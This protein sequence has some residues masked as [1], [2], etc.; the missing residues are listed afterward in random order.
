MNKKFDNKIL[1]VDDDPKNL[2]VAMN[3]LK[4]YNVI[5]AQSGEKALTLLEKNK[6]DLIL[7][8]IVMP[9]MDGYTVCKEIKKNINLRNIPIIFLTVK[10]EEKDIVK[11]FDLG[12][13]DYVTKP[14]FSQV[15]LKRV[16]SHLKLALVMDELK[17]MNSNLN[18][19]VEE[20]VNELRRKDKL[21][22]QQSRIDAMSDIIEVISQQWKVPLDKIKLYLQSL[23]LKLSDIETLENDSIFKN[24]ISEVNKLEKIMND[25]H[26]FFNKEV[27]ELV[28]LKV[29]IDNSVLSLKNELTKSKI[30]INI[31]GDI[32]LSVNIVFKEIEHIFTKLIS[33]S[34]ENFEENN[35]LRK[36][37]IN[38][39][40]NND[41]IFITF[42]D[43]SR[44]YSESE[45]KKLF[46]VPS[47]L[48]DKSFDLGYYLIKVFVE[49][50]TG[51]L[52]VKALDNG[53]KYIIRFDK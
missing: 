13:V 1:L 31:T 17:K 6:F 9:I 41:S 32:L 36:I 44:I 40:T 39:E 15:L 14:F 35:D 28:N 7:L 23:D 21:I 12:A 5:F 25:F 33:K 10:D 3:I 49:K 22:V 11:G 27:T 30:K 29:S 53:I 24:T 16:E 19:I 2:Q 47:F 45:I 37:D 34:I 46:E 50:N 42:E 26:K 4:D 48:N 51:I 18:S 43:N 38:F 52:L 20:Q 8:D